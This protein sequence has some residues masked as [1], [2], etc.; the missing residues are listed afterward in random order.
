MSNA[1]TGNLIGKSKA[2]ETPSVLDRITEESRRRAAQL[3]AIS[4]SPAKNELDFAAA[5]RRKGPMPQLIAELKRKSPS[6]GNLKE[7]LPV[8]DAVRMY[9]PYAAALSILTEPEHFSGAIEDLRDARALT[10]LPLLRKD[11]IVDV[12]QVD[13]ARAAGA[14]SF[15]LIVASLTDSELQTLIAHG[16]KLGMEPLVEVLTEAELERALRLDIAILGINNRNL[17]T[18]EIDMK[19]CENLAQLITERDRERLVLVAESGY[20]TREQLLALP[21]YFDAVLMGTGF[22]READ[23]AAKLRE[24]FGPGGAVV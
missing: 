19:R 22:M 20:E 17:H 9:E 7:G 23:P 6:K 5:L 21:H 1:H 2:A 11:F 18:L 24:I 12:K 15:L 16:R 3:V 4:P 10:A 14:T 8:A 13:E